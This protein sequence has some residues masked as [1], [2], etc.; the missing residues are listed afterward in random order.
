MVRQRPIRT[1]RVEPDAGAAKPPED[2]T[3]RPIRLGR[4][5]N[6]NL[7]GWFHM[8]WPRLLVALGVLGALALIA[9]L[10]LL[11]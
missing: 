3:R 7:P 11:R 9:W 8:L 10:L 4:P 1:H 5:A 6:D 2:T